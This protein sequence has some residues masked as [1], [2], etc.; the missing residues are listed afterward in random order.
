MAI[1][2]CHKLLSALRSLQLLSSQQ[3]DQVERELLPHYTDAFDLSAYLVE[4]DWLTAHQRRLLFEDRWNELTIGP[5]QILDRLGEGG[6]SE[7]FKAWDTIRGRIVALKVL[8]QHLATRPEAVEELRREQQAIVLLVHPN[9][10]KTYDAAQVDGLHYFA[11]EYVEGLDL[12]QYVQRHGPLTVEQACECVRQ[13]ATGL[14][15]A[16]Q[17][18]LVHRDVKPANLFLLHPSAD[19]PTAGPSRRRSGETVVKI[20]DWGLARLKSSTNESGSAPDADFDAEKGLLI[21]TADYLAPEQARDATLVDIRA[22]IYSLGCVFYYLLTGEPPF[23]APSLMQ[24][25]MQHRDEAPPA[26]QAKRPDVGDELNAV[27]LR[28]MAKQPEKRFQIPLLVAA[29]LRR[30]CSATAGGLASIAANAGGAAFRPSSSASLLRPA[31]NAAVQRPASS[32]NVIKSVRAG[33]LPR[34]KSENTDY[35]PLNKK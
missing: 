9:I 8:R 2:S 13:T 15:H 25:L 33:E 7:V 20:L 21:G 11:M 22:D 35:P 32:A 14:Q 10:I 24:K 34:P 31:S 28:M 30:F 3:G 27:V 6:A 18:G 19:A 29:A 17:A 5:Y 16:H 1:D 26:V 12:H 4:I 23:S